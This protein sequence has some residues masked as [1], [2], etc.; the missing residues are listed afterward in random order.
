ML[1]YTERKWGLTSESLPDSNFISDTIQCNNNSI[2]TMFS[3]L[4]QH[5][6]VNV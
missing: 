3:L 4:I 6:T 5:F 2:Y 1:L